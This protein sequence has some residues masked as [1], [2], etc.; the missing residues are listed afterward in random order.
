MLLCTYRS[1]IFNFVWIRVQLKA[2]ANPLSSIECVRFINFHD[3][4]T[5]AMHE[6]AIQADACKY[7]IANATRKRSRVTAKEFVP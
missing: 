4:T 2:T 5:R 6:G 3:N 7:A 1:R